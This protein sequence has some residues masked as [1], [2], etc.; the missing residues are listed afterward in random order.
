M[1]R[2]SAQRSF[3]RYFDAKKRDSEIEQDVIDAVFHLRVW[4]DI[5]PGVSRF[6]GA[7]QI[8]RD[9]SWRVG[10]FGYCREGG[11][12]ER[13]RVYGTGRGRANGDF[14]NLQ[15]W[16]FRT[17]LWELFVCGLQRYDEDEIFVV[18]RSQVEAS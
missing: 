16:P 6:A 2:S 15:Q 7:L 12:L 18:V 11:L 9:R 10:Q 17:N 13:R 8:T 1:I 14:R 3:N 4:R 5:R